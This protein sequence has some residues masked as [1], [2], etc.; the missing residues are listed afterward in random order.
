M[1]FQKG[2]PPGP[3]RP[4]GSKNKT[5]LVPEQVVKKVSKLKRMAQARAALVDAPPADS[6]TPELLPAVP[7]VKVRVNSIKEALAFMEREM[8]TDFVEAVWDGLKVR[9]DDRKFWAKIYADVLVSK[10]Q[11]RPRDIAEPIQFITRNQIGGSYDPMGK[12][13]EDEAQPRSLVASAPE[14]ESDDDLVAVR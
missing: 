6:M 3:G 12:P 10:P 9:D 11:H 13:P 8:S 2:G 7:M 14:E 4:K 1:A 5:V